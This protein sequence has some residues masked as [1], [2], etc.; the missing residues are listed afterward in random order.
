MVTGRPL[1]GTGN[2]SKRSRMNHSFAVFN[3]H[4]NRAGERADEEFVNQFGQERFD[5]HIRP[6]RDNG[7][8]AIFEKTPASFAGIWIA[9]CTAYANEGQGRRKR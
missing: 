3:L 1:R 8:M 4:I 7:I 2:L 6:Y 5:R 9:L